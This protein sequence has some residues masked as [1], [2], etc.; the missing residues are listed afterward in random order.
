MA[1]TS[2]LRA[3]LRTRRRSID[4]AE[5]AAAATRVADR[6]LADE[7]IATARSVAYY[8]P[9]D[10]ELSLVPT[11][12]RLRSLG[13]R[14]HLPVLA[15]GR[16]VFRCV[17]DTTT[18]T[19]NRYGIAEPDPMDDPDVEAAALDVCLA[20][21]VAVDLAGNRMG[22]GAGWYD[23]TFADPSSRPLLIATVHDLQVLDRLDAAPHDV[24]MD[25]V[26]TPTRWVEL[27][28]PAGPTP[29]QALAD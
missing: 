4:D 9:F 16:L 8:L 18:W 5:Q 26:A 28:G 12:E 27:G 10:G 15:D 25:A 7:R 3:E 17:D 13:V 29:N 23:R 22:M 1:P 6:L 24:A 20:P 14:C 19:V 21:A 2:S 11:A